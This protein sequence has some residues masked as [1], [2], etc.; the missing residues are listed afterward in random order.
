M[1]KPKIL[2]VDD[3]PEIVKIFK[4]YLDKHIECETIGA[5][6]GEEALKKIR[7]QKFDLIILDIKMPG[8]SGLDVL[9]EVE[10]R[11]HAPAILVSTAWDSTQIADEVI[12]EGAADYIT[13]PIKLETLKE[14][15]RSI[16]E[17]KGKYA[18]KA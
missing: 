14:K 15:I 4:D 5:T 17:R 13:K 8:V 6:E 11:P 9:K 2:I 7:S 1:Q 12:K 18:Q 16:L 10:K 3:E